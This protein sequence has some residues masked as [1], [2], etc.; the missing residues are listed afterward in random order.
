MVWVAPN[1]VG[2]KPLPTERVCCRHISML[3]A[4]HPGK[5]SDL[6]KALASQTGIH[7]QFDQRLN[8]Y[9]QAYLQ[10]IQQAPPACKHVFDGRQLGRYLTALAEA[11]DAAQDNEADHSNTT[12]EVN[13]LLNTDNHCMTL[14]M[15]R[16][17]RQEQT[18]FAVKLY[19]PNHT[20]HY[21]R[22]VKPTAQSLSS[23][24][25][26]D[27]LADSGLSKR[28]SVGSNQHISLSAVCLNAD[29]QPALDR[30][31]VSASAQHLHLAL[32]DGSL[33]DVQRFLDASTQSLHLEPSKSGA[34][35]E[36]LQA[37]YRP[38]G[39]T[40][41][42]MALHNGHVDAVKTYTQWVLNAD[43]HDLSRADKVSLLSAPIRDNTHGLYM[44]FQNGH[45]QAVEVFTLCILNA[46]D[47]VLSKD[48]KI[49]LLKACKDN[50]T[51]GLF[52]ALYNGHTQAIN[53]FMYC[54]LNASDHHLSQAD[55]VNL[56]TPHSGDGLSGLRYAL[57]NGF[58]Q[59]AKAFEANIKASF[60]DVQTKAALLTQAWLNLDSS[61]PTER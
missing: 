54:I 9:N 33:I 61:L 18:Y 46:K 23:L 35:F 22:V 60:W 47:H 2:H 49:K 34:S 13:C 55:K 56:L 19:D 51:P 36:L 45:A 40:G 50:G 4:Q 31:M 44:A 59:A 21:T 3:F 37:Q 30:T 24:Q 32:F 6:I 7:A 42:F 57:Q 1:L 39:P 43:E 38:Q 10:A 48:D 12:R 25:F 27:L 14:H 29:L 28:Y 5:K 52:I 15:Q 8:R 20:A 58:A 17:V 53:N 41:V 26:N 16:K 11:L